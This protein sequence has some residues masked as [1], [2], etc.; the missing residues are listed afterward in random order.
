MPEGRCT[1]CLEEEEEEQCESC[2]KTCCSNCLEEM[3]ITWE[4]CQM[5]CPQCR[6][7]S[8]PRRV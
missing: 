4:L 2:L 6:K 5:W 3:R 8:R 1:A 7:D